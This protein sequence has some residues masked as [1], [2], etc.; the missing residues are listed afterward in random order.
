MKKIPAISFLLLMACESFGFQAIDLNGASFE[1]IAVLPGIGKKLAQNIVRHRERHGPFSGLN[2][3]KAVSG[4]TE[5]KLTEFQH[6]VVFLRSARAKSPSTKQPTK[7]VSS[8][9]PKRSIIGFGA[10]LG[11]VLQIHGLDRGFEQ[12]LSHRV[13]KAAYLPTLTLVFDAGQNRTVSDRARDSLPN[14]RLHRGGHDFGFSVRATFDLDKLIFSKDELEV[15][16]LSLTRLDKRDKLMEELKKHYFRYLELVGCL[17]NGD[18]QVAA[19]QALEIKE[20]E[21]VL[22]AMSNGEFSRF[23]NEARP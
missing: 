6:K 2:A 7:P 5:K 15:A 10:L 22:D 13:R 3:V 19:N 18:D 17:E 12:S 11:K 23:T 20:I 14:A 16:K 9:M 4:M 8:P 21:A 1:Q